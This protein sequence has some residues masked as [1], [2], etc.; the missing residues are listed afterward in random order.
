[1]IDIKLIRE[2]CGFYRREGY[3]DGA[4]DH[5]C[6]MRHA[7]YSIYYP[8]FKPTNGHCDITKCPMFKYTKSIDSLRY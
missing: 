7:R 2:H 3:K 6:D 4:D 8:D 5:F 1:M